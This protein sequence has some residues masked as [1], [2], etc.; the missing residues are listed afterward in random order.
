MALV[1]P[2]DQADR[3]DFYAAAIYGSIVSA[4]LLAAFHEEHV[5]AADALAALLSTAV[6]FWLAHAWSTI[7]A[8]RIHLGLAFTLRQALHVARAEWP[9]VES[10]LV[11]SIVLLLGWTGVFSD[12][13]AIDV[14]TAV[15]LLQ[16]LG[17]GF[18]VGRRAYHRWLQAFAAGIANGAVGVALVALEVAVIHR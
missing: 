15:C 1:T 14:A 8:E 10:T 18:V 5:P 9:L 7:V 16:L 4:A 6:V 2:P 12:Q 11:P 13:S 3:S 17:W